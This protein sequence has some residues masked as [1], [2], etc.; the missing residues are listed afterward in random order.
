VLDLH[1][2]PGGQSPGWHSD[3]VTSHASFWDHRD[4]QDRTVWLWKE[5]AARYRS[6]TWIAGYNPINEPCDP[7][8]VRLPAYYARIEKEIRAIDPDHILFLDGNTF[9]AEW[10]GFGDHPILPNSVY[11]LHDYSSLGFPGPEQFTRSQDQLDRLERQFL[12]KAEFQ[13]SK[14]LPIWNGEFGPVYANPQYEVDAADINRKRYE[15][16]AEQLR[17][18]DKFEIPWSIWLYKDI[19]VQG[20]LHTSPSSPWNKLLQPFLE[21]KKAHQLDAWGKYPSEEVD[22][23]IRPLVEWIDRINPVA[24]TIYPSTWDTRRHIDRAVLQTFLAE[25]FQQEFASLFK[26][27]TME[28]LHALAKSFAFDQCVQ[29]QGL[30]EMLSKHAE[31]SRH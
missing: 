7:E 14:N 5:I 28:E 12:R 17:I 6:N 16:L 23:L 4:F 11:A 30:N 8:H 27:K 18:Y 9:A 10:Q 13:L 15:L 25:S 29:R 19:G 24:K 26:D 31:T 3:N 22:A 2:L 21:K 20:M 1:T